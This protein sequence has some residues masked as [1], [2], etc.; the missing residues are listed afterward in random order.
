MES[1]FV[2]EECGQGFVEKSEAEEHLVY[3]HEVFDRYITVED[4]AN[5]EPGGL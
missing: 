4:P 1:R 3:N 2:C 5:A